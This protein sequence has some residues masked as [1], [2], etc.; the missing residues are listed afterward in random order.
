MDWGRFSFEYRLRLDVLTS[1]LIRIEASREA[2][3]N[4]VLPPDWKTQLDQ[5]N[6]VR[7]V[8]GTTALEGNPLSEAQVRQQMELL[9]SPTAPSSSP[10]RDQRQV[11]NAGRAQDWVRERFTPEAAPLRRSD[12]LR[13]HELAT[14]GSDET[15]NVPGRLRTHPVV[16]GAEALGGVHRGAPPQEVSR[17]VDQFVAF[18]NSR[19]FMANH[20]VV[21]ALLAHFFL[22]TIHPFGDGN[23][24]VSR[25]VEAGILFQG[26]YN[27]Y[28]FYGLSNYFYRHGD[29]YKRLLQQSRHTQ[30]FDLNAFVAF[31][32][33]GF[34]AELKGINNFIKTKL[35]RVVYRT[36]LVRAFN[37]RAGKRRRVINQREYGLLDF[38]LQETEPIDPFAEEPSRRIA[39]SE[40]RQAPYVKEV[41]RRVT[42]RTFYRELTRLAEMGFIKFSIQEPE[43]SIE[44]DF[45]AIGRY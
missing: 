35:N 30:P 18:V 39:Y 10:S 38:L 27:V 8:H 24:R 21:R 32:V 20:P 37:Q 29:E 44:I 13:M 19:S 34:A 33:E 36:T 26:E 4:L 6:R 23:G 17:L 15:D 42:A 11:L 9:A 31:G 41:Y 1:D 28:G 7:A 40:L 22:V 16:V 3:L 5:L 45:G 25:L 14:E 43:P 12:I 2:A